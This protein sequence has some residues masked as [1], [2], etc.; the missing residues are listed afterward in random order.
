MYYI[1]VFFEK[2]KKFIVIK[3]KILY[4]KIKYGKRIKIGKGLKF[5]KGFIINIDKNGFLEIGNNNFFNNYCSLNIHDKLIIG[6]DNNF[7]ENVKL[8][9]HNKVFNDKKVDMKHTYK[10]SKIT[11]G[12]Y[13]WIGSNVVILKNASL[14][15][16]NVVAAGLVLNDKYSD[17][18]LINRKNDYEVEKINYK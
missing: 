17:E 13:N 4:W 8:Y 7:G 2:V 5:R 1:C 16:Y 10:T 11:M 18:N 9:D 14:G 3:S 12:N 15:N 6:N